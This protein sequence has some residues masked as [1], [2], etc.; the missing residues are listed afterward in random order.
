M[1]VTTVDALLNVKPVLQKIANTS[2]PAKSAFS[3]LRT[4]KVV[5]KEYEAIEAAQRVLLDKYGKKDSSGNYIADENGNFRIEESKMNLYV[6]EMK[7][8]LAEKVEINCG[9]I[10][11]SVFE[12]LDFTPAQLMMIE[13]FIEE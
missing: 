10:N 12:Q 2:M 4:L 6:P 13:D 7:A 1:I 8:L 9:K 5:E 3:V 11:S